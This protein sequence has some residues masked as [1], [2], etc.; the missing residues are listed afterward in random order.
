MPF[1]A[2]TLAS[3]GS[4]PYRLVDDRCSTA[5]A[6]LIPHTLRTVA[7]RPR[8]GTTAISGVSSQSIPKIRDQPVAAG[9]QPDQMGQ[10]ANAHQ[11]ID[12]SDRNRLHH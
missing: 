9:E 4:A 2:I 7:I 3:G 1:P 10:R 11:D 6:P 12:E 5:T 8:V